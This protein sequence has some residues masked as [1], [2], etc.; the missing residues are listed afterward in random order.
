MKQ[1]KKTA[2]SL[3]LRWYNKK[4]QQNISKEELAAFIR[5]SKNKDILTQT[6]D[7]VNSVVIFDKGTY[8]K[9]LKNLLN[10]Q[11]K[12]ENASIEKMLF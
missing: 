5:L 3:L 7:K 9:R 11:R 4:L 10:N 12:F 2:L 8:I 6:S 1:S